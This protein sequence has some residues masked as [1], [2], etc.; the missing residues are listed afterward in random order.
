M[1]KLSIYF[2]K[3]DAALNKY[4]A[5]WNFVPFQCDDYPWQNPSLI[6]YLQLLADNSKLTHDEVC[7]QISEQFFPELTDA[8]QSIDF[9]QK[10]LVDD[11]YKPVP[12]WLQNGIHGRK[13]T[14][15]Q[16]LSEQIK[17]K[18]PLLEWCAGKGHLGRLLS[19]QHNVAVTSVE[20]Q[21]S[22]CEQGRKLAKT[23]EI[24]QDFI[25]ADVLKQPATWLKPHQHVVALHACGDLHV[26]LLKQAV[27]AKVE[28]M[29]V[30]PC[31][32]H[33]IAEQTYPALSALGQ[34]SGLTIAKAI[35]KLAVQAQVTAGQRVA[36]LRQTEVLWRLAYQLI[37]A[38]ISGET[39]YK[40]LPSVKKSWFSGAFADF[41]DWGINHQGL[42]LPAEINFADYL[43]RAAVKQK[44][45][46]Q[47]EYVRHTFQRAL[48][49]WLVLDKALFLE[50]S[51]YQVEINYF[52]PY[53]TTPR[54]MMIVAKL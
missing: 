38:D 41:V 20:W 52:C 7:H 44:F 10:Q 34:A 3:L 43:Q 11:W 23:Y 29:H 36:N 39:G 33:L 45:I 46:Q 25:H 12:F 19:F 50:Q 4:Q 42:V 31:C 22:L 35:L 54:N 27:A 9:L 32:Y 47:L 13:I 21:K 51:G 40:S 6:Q 17:P 5:Y 14:Q 48:E 49:H 2:D 24:Q 16:Q 37:R 18:Y 26:T 53:Q 30:A 28:Y 8:M 1:S 15:V